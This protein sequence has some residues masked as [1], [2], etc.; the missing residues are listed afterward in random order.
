M[1]LA[2][3]EFP[4]SLI[5]HSDETSV[6]GYFNDNRLDGIICVN[7]VYDCYELSFFFVNPACQHRGMGQYL[8]RSILSRFNDKNL[9]LCVYKDNSRAIHIYRK[10]GFKIIK[11][12]YDKG[13]RPDKPHY[14]MQKN[15]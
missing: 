10:Y 8:F 2:P 15:I 14:V 13:Y 3:D 12:A 7:D 4:F 11:T 9:K 6:Y 1:T 5:T